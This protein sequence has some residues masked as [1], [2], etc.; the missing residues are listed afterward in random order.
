MISDSAKYSLNKLWEKKEVQ[1]TEDDKISINNFYY[2]YR[3]QIYPENPEFVKM[4]RKEFF[5]TLYFRSITHNELPAE[6]EKTPEPP[7]EEKQL[8]LNF[9]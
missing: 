9:N 3:K 4:E 8:A 5:D 1:F 7:K 6:S 2:R